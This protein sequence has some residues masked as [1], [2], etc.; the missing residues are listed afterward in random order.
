MGT[1]SEVNKMNK[2]EI[3]SIPNLNFIK[4]LIQKTLLQTEIQMFFC[5]MKTIRI[6]KV[7]NLQNW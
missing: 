7:L 5:Q 3:P 2:I 1:I 4:P 6:Y